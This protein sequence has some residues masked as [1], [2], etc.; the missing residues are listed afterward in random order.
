MTSG[1]ID[2]TTGPP[3]PGGMTTTRSPAP[4]HHLLRTVLRL[5][6]TASGALGVAGLVAAPA[7]GDL[8]GAPAPAVLGV[9]AFLA[10]SAGA[11]VALAARPVLHR[12]LVRTV[13]LGNAGWVGASVLVAILAPLTTAGV[14][15][16]LV[17]AVAVAAFAALQ[18]L[19]LRRLR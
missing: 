15:V 1:V 7:L 9:G 17:Q 19:G 6:A 13:V 3:D 16:V 12:P 5:D 10:G 2:R 4:T 14:V 11:L 18:G 8:L